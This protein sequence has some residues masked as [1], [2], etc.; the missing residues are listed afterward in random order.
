EYYVSR[1]T[2]CEAL[3]RMRRLLELA[4]PL[5]IRSNPPQM[6]DHMS[7]TDEIVCC[8]LLFGYSNYARSGY[9][10][11]LI[12][13]TNVPHNG[14]GISAGSILGGA[15]LAVSTAAK[16]RDA[17]CEYATY[18]ASP[19]V[20]RTT[21]VEQSGQPGYRTAWLDSAVNRRCANFFLA[22]LTTLDNAY[23]RPRYRGY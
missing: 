9:R 3:D 22:T 11:N 4:H 19:T 8:P 21:Y 18:V 2:G 14:E 17:A 16:N 6:L 13:F 23:M 1:S 12:Q 7:R 10:P 15:G 20:Q 5:S